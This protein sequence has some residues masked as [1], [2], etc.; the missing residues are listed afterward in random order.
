MSTLSFTT[1]VEQPERVITLTPASHVLLLGSC[2]ADHVGKHLVESMPTGH[3]VVNPFGPLYDAVSLCRALSM[4]RDDVSCALT[5][6][7]YFCGRDGLW[8]NW[9]FAGL[10]SAPT[11][12]ACR[13]EAEA[14][15]AE[16]HNCFRRAEL[17]V[18]TL[19]TDHVYTLRER[20]GFVVANCHKEP[21][22]RFCRETCPVE[23]LVADWTDLLEGIGGAED[24]RA[25]IVFTLSPYRYTKY[26]LHE[27]ALTKARLLCVIDALCGQ[28]AHAHYF[29][30]YEIV[31]DELRDYRFYASDML[32]PSDVAVDYVWQRFREWTFSPELCDYAD[33]RGRLLRELAHRPLHPDS[34]EA[35]RFMEERRARWRAFEEEDKKYDRH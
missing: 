20:P 9:Y 12:E 13:A 3:V 22:A 24:R 28:H 19:S 2:F 23:R 15:L 1:P 18:L 32:H 35:R 27:N 21:A 31:T 30:A 11:L 10:V 29:P 33:R 4:V 25:Q 34:P 8:H 26:G 14:R 6:D 17:I 7:T 16:A 5:D